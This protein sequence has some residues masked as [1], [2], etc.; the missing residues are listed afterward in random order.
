MS[1]DIAAPFEASY[2]LQKKHVQ[3]SKNAYILYIE[4]TKYKSKYLTTKT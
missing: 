1:C 3:F 2:Y 4:K